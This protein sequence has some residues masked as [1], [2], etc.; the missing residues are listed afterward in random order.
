MKYGIIKAVCLVILGCMVAM[1]AAADGSTVN[2]TSIILESFNGETNHQWFD[3]RHSRSY[4]FSWAMNASRFATSTTDA[5]GAEVSFP[6]S[7]YVQAWPIALY[8]HNRDGSRELR[9]M[10]IN[11][12]FDR[13][14]FNWIDIFPVQMDGTTPFEI[15]M[16]GRVQ[17][18]D[19]WVWGANHDFYLEAFVRD[20]QGIV[21]RIW[22][23]H[24]RHAGW[25][26]LR[27]HIPRH[28]RQEKLILPALAQLNFV[29][30]RLWTN[31]TERVDN[32][33]VYLNQFKI[34]TDTFETFF[35]G[36]DL[37]D[38]DLNQEFWANSGNTN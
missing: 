15:P 26:N 8:G 10:G 19:L 16:P 34:L 12:R 13:Q 36:D 33:F 5:D 17:Y 9:S 37:A 29:K 31:P 22:L 28:I 23:G 21:H 1:S 30:F 2:L 24:T 11:G 20:Y 32:F 18:M 35:D 3:G 25:R 27:A 6:V 14:G 4:D 7:T 38:P